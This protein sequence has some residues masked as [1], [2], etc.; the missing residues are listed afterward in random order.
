MVSVWLLRIP[1][2]ALHLFFTQV[3]VAGKY[4][5]NLEFMQWFK[6][7]CN[8][9]EVIFALKIENGFMWQL[10]AVNK[11]A[12]VPCVDHTTESLPRNACAHSSLYCP[13]PHRPIL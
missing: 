7:F 9:H 5:D 12:S 1:R 10:R 8:K 11:K 4:Q 2:W 3:A 13:P 6:G